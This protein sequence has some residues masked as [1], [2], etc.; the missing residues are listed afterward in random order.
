[1]NYQI[2]EGE[3]NILE[4]V[5]DQLDLVIGLLAVDG[6]EMGAIT[7]SSLYSFLEGRRGQLQGV[8]EALEKRYVVQRE[9]D[10]WQ[11]A[12]LYF[13]WMH[14]L[15]IA[16]GDTRYTPN[17]TEARIQEK[18]RRASQIDPNM[19]HVLDAWNK[20]LARQY[21]PQPTTPVASPKPPAKPRKREKLARGEA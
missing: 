3:F 8:I 16:S 11:G 14:A 4:S 18:L 19:G 10:A 9:M 13:D 15:Q 12:M 6:V 17:G 21:G 5:R 7:S 2:S 1:M 20:A